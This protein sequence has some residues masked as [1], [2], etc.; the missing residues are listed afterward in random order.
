VAEG[1]HEQEW[2]RAVESWVRWQQRWSAMTEPLD[3]ALV[4]AAGVCS[5]MKVLDLACG[6]GDPAIALARAVGRTGRIMA[7]D[8]V[9]GML[10]AARRRLKEAGLTNVELRRL[11]LGP[12]PF[13]DGSFDAVTCR[14]GLVYA[15]DPI[16]ASG[17]MRR[18]LRGNGR[19]AI[20]VWGDPARNE[21]WSVELDALAMLPL[22]D[23]E[24]PDDRVEFAYAS[25]GTLAAVLRAAGLANVREEMLAP[26]LRWPGPPEELWQQT[27]EDLAELNLPT[28][29]LERLAAE[30]R[31]GYSAL[32]DGDGVV[33]RLEVILG[34][35]ECSR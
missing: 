31:R 22:P 35:G 17:E 25:P 1:T 18:V 13:P 4:R 6:T 15:D 33:M 29:A 5:G 8:P 26:A 12:L 3:D 7:A 2:E 20:M 23:S 16:L 14:F 9:A 32:A 10:E 30:V 19:V 27:A 11:G 34:T 24:P 21:Y 28:A